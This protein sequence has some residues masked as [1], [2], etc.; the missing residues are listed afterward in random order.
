MD[1]K[2]KRI[3]EL[4]QRIEQLN[5]WHQQLNQEI[6]SLQH[7]IHELQK[8]RPATQAM[9]KLAEPGPVKQ[10]ETVTIKKVIIEPSQ[11]TEPPAF[12]SAEKAKSKT[13]LEEFIGTNLL[14]KIGIAVLVIGIGFGAKY[15]IDHQLINPLTRIISG[16]FWGTV[17]IVAA[18]RLKGKKKY[19]NFSAVL[20]SGGMT[21][22][23]FIT[24]AAYDFY[25]LIPRM[26]AFALMLVFTAFTVFASL[27]YNLQVI[28]VI[29]LVGAYGLPFLL[30]DNSGRVSVLFSYMTI[31]N[32]GILV[33]A[34]KRS[35]KL[36]NNLAFILTWLIFSSWYASDYSRENHF[37]IS[38]VFGT[39][40]FVIFYL[41]LLAYKI[42]RGE[43]LNRWDIFFTLAN[44]FIYFGFGYATIDSQ[45]SGEQF[46]G[47]FTV[48]TALIHFA[49]CVILYRKQNTSKDV[50]YFIAGLVLVFLTLAVPVQLNG[51]WVTLV[52]ASEALV[53][54]W[55]GRTKKFPIYEKLSYP[56][57]LLAFL[58][59]M[60]DWNDF[61]NN[62]Y[63]Y[64]LEDMPGIPFLLNIQFM[65]SILT[66]SAV[67]CIYWL[68]RNPKFPP[69]FKK[70][71]ILYNVNNFIL[72]ALVLLIVYISFYLE[73]SNYWEQRYAASAVT[74]PA[75]NYTTY[76]YELRRFKNI[77]LIIYTALFAAVLG[78]VNLRYLRN[79]NLTTIGLALNSF[80]LFIFLTGGLLELSYLR[81]SYLDQFMTEYY[82]RSIY[83]VLIRY[84]S[85]AA[86]A[87]LVWLNY[88]YARETFFPSSLRK[89]E[90]VAFHLVVLTLLSSELVHWLNMNDIHDTF[91]FALSILWGSYALY[92]IIYG[93]WKSKKY[94]RITGITLFG[95]TLAKLFL[96]DMAGMSTIA[97]TVV[98]II[99]GVLLLVAS[100]LYNKYKDL[101]TNE[102]E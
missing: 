8:E 12:T 6:R 16:Y 100:F 2:D 29:G 68:S 21:V 20:L 46:L 83:Y 88:R 27:Q 37:W 23:Y 42:I 14:N 82:D 25:D 87:P 54:F 26:L 64:A 90:R 94:L 11:T 4:S 45:E 15:A 96:Y 38:L 35:W 102:S 86:M 28:A 31:V 70:E 33:I 66:A 13:P 39:V 52:W 61:Y 34:F 43:S 69:P 44:S 56:L 24:F 89:I 58:S 74:S 22:L 101:L 99:L 50:F 59:L 51:N 3:N 1:E 53:L 65:T 7:T 76:D 55:I 79:K 95:I 9:E 36:L 75:D 91:K 10:P 85:L 5:R 17:L 32:A 98:M 93:I 40:F 48:F 62:R 67:G 78:L 41:T 30:S 63:Y 73:I 19:E 57:I 97:R 18:I 84:I 47:L 71:T 80:V 92:L 81:R 60:Q 77:W 72:P 49:V